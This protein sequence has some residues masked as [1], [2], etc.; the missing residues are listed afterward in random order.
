MT[1]PF[2]LWTFK[3]ASSEKKIHHFHLQSNLKKSLYIHWEKGCIES[4][5]QKMYENEMSHTH[6]TQ[7]ILQTELFS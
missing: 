1:A 2:G 3:K 7:A 4:V 6:N 5:N